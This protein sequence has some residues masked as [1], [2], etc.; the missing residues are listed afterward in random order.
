[1]FIWLASVRERVY[2]V[3]DGWLDGYGEELLVLLRYVYM[4][5]SI[6]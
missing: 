6:Q 4:V 1:M 3:A 5:D 2:V